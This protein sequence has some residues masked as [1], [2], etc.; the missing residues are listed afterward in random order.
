MVGMISRRTSS[1]APG[2]NVVPPPL[3]D[4]TE[5]DSPTAMY[6]RVFTVRASICV[7]VPCPFLLSLRFSL[8]LCMDVFACVFVSLCIRICFFV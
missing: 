4:G 5:D 7:C 3:F 1:D 6:K 2:A 8:N